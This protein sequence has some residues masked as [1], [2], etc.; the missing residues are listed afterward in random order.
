[1]YRY[2]VLKFKPMYMSVGIFAKKL[3]MTQIFDQDGTID[4]CYSCSK[5]NHA[6]SRKLKQL[7]KRPAIM[8]IQVSLHSEVKPQNES[9]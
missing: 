9:N 5:L 8:L 3:G 7:R 4:S 2:I 1:L 6:K